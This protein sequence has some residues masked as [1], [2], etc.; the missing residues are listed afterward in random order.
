MKFLPLC[1][2]RIVL[3]CLVV[4]FATQFV[5]HIL[6][7][8]GTLSLTSTIPRSN[9][10]KEKLW[11]FKNRDN[12]VFISLRY[13]ASESGNAWIDPSLIIWSRKRDRLDMLA[14]LCICVFTKYVNK[15]AASFSLCAASHLDEELS[16]AV[17]IQLRTPQMPEEQ[18]ERD[19]RVHG[20]AC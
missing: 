18:S 20:V 10:G 4:Y 19:V 5:T 14:F 6:P 7:F 13:K 16:L 1:S 9:N 8:G 11:W 3:I 17:K 2:V 12:L 15:L